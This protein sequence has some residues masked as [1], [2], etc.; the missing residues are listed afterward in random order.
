M[1]RVSSRDIIVVIIGMIIT[2]LLTISL[3]LKEFKL[4]EPELADLSFPIIVT[5]AV[6]I[7]IAVVFYMKMREI[8]KELDDQ[9]LEQKKPNEKLKIYERLSKIEKKVFNNGNKSQ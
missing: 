6:I 9:R 3:Q 1:E 2:I 8:N 4:F 5:I 7:S